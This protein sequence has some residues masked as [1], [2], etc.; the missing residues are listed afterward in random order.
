M[1]L[2]VQIIIK[3]EFGEFFGEKV[4]LDQD[5]LS[6]IIEASK[7]FYKSGGFELH[8]ED[9]SFVVFP[10]D[11]VKKSILKIISKKIEDKIS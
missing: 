6:T 11:I 7:G 10:A 3:N 9:G 5:K 8:C 2:E 1:K 4:I